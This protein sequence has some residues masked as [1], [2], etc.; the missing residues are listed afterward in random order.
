MKILDKI[1]QAMVNSCEFSLGRAFPEVSWEWTLKLEMLSPQQP[2]VALLRS[3]SSGPMGT[4]A[5]EAATR[6]NPLNG[7]ELMQ[8]I[9]AEI[10]T[11]LG[12]EEELCPNARQRRVRWRWEL[13]TSSFWPDAG[14]FKVSANGEIAAAPIEATPD[15]ANEETGADAV[16]QIEPEVLASAVTPVADP[17][18]PEGVATVPQSGEVD[19]GAVE[20][21]AQRVVELLQR[22]ES[23]RLLRRDLQK[24]LWRFGRT[25]FN[26][27]IEALLGRQVI[28]LEGPLVCL[29]HTTVPQVAEGSTDRTP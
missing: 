28:R 7:L 29:F 3:K 13:A 17:F 27:A 16:C 9:L 4:A 20:R 18:R 15:A 19:S 10:A 11:M 6:G 14:N 21:C 25:P 26:R 12:Q 2:T 23:G 1:E 22:A 5:C 24:S 8:A